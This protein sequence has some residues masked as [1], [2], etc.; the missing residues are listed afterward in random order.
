MPVGVHWEAVDDGGE[1]HHIGDYCLSV[2]A[3]RERRFCRPTTTA[4]AVLSTLRYAYHLDAN[5]YARFLRAHAEAAGVVRV[6]GR[7]EGVEQDSQSGFIS[8]LRLADGR[9]VQGE[10][11]VDCSGFRS[12]LLGDTLGV[13]YRSWQ[14][15]LPC[16]RAIAV[17]SAISGPP[18]PYTRVTAGACGWRWRIPLQHRI[19]NGH[20]FSSEHIGEAAALDELIA[21]LD[22]PP[23]AEPRTLRFI[24]GRRDRLWDKNCVAIGLSGGFIEPLESTAIHLIQSGI[25]KLMALFPDSGFD[26]R[27]IEEYNRTLIDEYEAIRDFIILHYCATERTDSDFWNHCR[28]MT[29]PDSLTEKLELWRGKGRLFR[30][31]SDL[32]TE[33]SWIAVLLGQRLFPE[34]YDPLAETLP[35]DESARFLASIREVIHKT[36]MAMPRHEDFIDRYCAPGARETV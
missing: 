26:D 1:V 33:D 18:L 29:V 21:G 14:Q 35:F 30:N 16:D 13:P 2:V 17:P 4:G 23:S 19:G 22:G 24:A 34:S 11:F 8:S 5:L 28:T 36:A 25:F 3:G 9:A 31:Q 27:E 12:L 15:W 7:I 32:F 6:E 20:V 10:F